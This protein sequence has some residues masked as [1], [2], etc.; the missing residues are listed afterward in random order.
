MR[1]LVVVA[2]V[3]TG[4][5]ADWQNKRFILACVNITTPVFTW[6]CPEKLQ[7]PLLPDGEAAPDAPK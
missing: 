6:A 7:A 4:C 1:I 5:A 2:L 3:L